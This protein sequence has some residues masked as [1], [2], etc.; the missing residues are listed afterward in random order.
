MRKGIVKRHLKASILAVVGSL[1]LAS[2]AYAGSG[3]PQTITHQGRLYDANNQPVT[4]KI[5]VTFAIYDAADA[6][7]PLWSDKISIDFEEG[8]FSATL[9]GPQMPF[10]DKVF[11]GSVRYLGVTVGADPEM[12]PRAAVQSVPYA[13]VAGDAV[14]DIHPTSVWVGGNIVIDGTGQWVGDPTGLQGPAG[15][16]GIQGAQGLA[17]E[18]GRAHV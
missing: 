3:V 8:Y 1:L 14:G 4:G 15:P 9:G 16:Q 2:T 11:D 18:I 17:G 5:D 10:D 13:I 12:A 7:T 6:S